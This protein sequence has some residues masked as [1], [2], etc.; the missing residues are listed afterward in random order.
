LEL[1]NLGGILTD[2]PLRSEELGAAI[3]FAQAVFGGSDAKSLPSFVRNWGEFQGALLAVGFKSEADF[4]EIVGT[5]FVAAPGLALSATHVFADRFEAMGNGKTVPYALGIDGEEVRIW[6]IRSVNTVEDDD[7]ALLSLQAASALPNSRKYFQFPLTT[8]TPNEGEVLQIFGFRSEH[9][10]I[11]FTGNVLAA[12]GTV[13]RVH[14][15][16][17]D[18]LLL[19]YPVIEIA[20]GSLGGMSGGVAIDSRGHVLGVISRGVDTAEQTGPTY[21]AWVIKALIRRTKL[22]W[23]PG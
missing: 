23:P 17:R 2:D 14:P 18:R 4:L 11:G 9:I 21:C 7:I 12:S 15:Q 19:P 22:D 6:R 5:A 13:Q 3:Q 1:K 10:T 20:A 8:R 16:G